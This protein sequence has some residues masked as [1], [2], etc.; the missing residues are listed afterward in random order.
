MAAKLR[1]GILVDSLLKQQ[2]LTTVI[3]Q[4][5]HQVGFRG[6]ASLPATDL[7][8]VNKDIDAWIIDIAESP[9]A[10]IH[11]LN[12]VEPRALDYLL[13]HVTVPV[14]LNDSSDHAS[15]SAEH[16]A[17]LR[18]I[19]QRLR[20]LSGEVNLQLAERTS[21]LWVL[22]ASTGG[23]AAVK[24]FLSHLP[25]AL[26]IAFIYVQH[27]DT[28]YA[29]T[30]LKMMGTA[31]SYPAAL[32]SHGCVLQADTLT[33]VTAERRVDVLQNGT[34]AITNESWSGCYSPSIDQLAA[35]VAR[36]YRERSG[37]IIFTG[38]GDD[39]AASGRL[40]KQ[41]G[42]QVWIQSPASCTSSSMPESALA[43]DCVSYSGTPTELAQHLALFMTQPTRIALP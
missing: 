11:E 21:H 1:I 40:I 10:G 31:G 35:N 24:E 37:L 6:M 17:W 12:A 20:H 5:Q 14:I 27:I 38:M 4:S 15:G 8:D 16:S 13:E 43:T 9:E 39:G 41:Q 36:I 42:G 3:A 2:Y 28:P 22:A 23:P 34:L 19:T 7:P 32:A 18:R 33:L 25:G 26:G 30:L 29:P